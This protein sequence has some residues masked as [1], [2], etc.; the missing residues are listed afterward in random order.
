LIKNVFPYPELRLLNII[1]NLR[2]WQR[3]GKRAPHKPFLLL[4]ALSRIQHNQKRLVLFSDI[5]K[6]RTELLIEFSPQRKSYHPEE[7]FHRLPKDGLWELANNQGVINTVGKKFTKTSLRNEAIK[8][9]F[10]AVQSAVL[11][12]D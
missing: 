5:E 8:G 11:M 9:G 2:V 6:K 12:S 1:L 10:T 4:I 7:P 3:G